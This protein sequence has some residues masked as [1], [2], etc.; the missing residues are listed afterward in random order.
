MTQRREASSTVH[1]PGLLGSLKDALAAAG[2]AEAASAPSSP[3]AGLSAPE[4]L[5]PPIQLPSPAAVAHAADAQRQSQDGQLGGADPAARGRSLSAA[6]AARSARGETLSEPGSSHSGQAAVSA[7]GFGGR[8]AAGD[9]EPPPTTRVVKAPAAPGAAQ[10]QFVRGKQKVERGGLKTDP[11][12]GWLV[13]VGGPGIGNYRP[14]FEGNNTMG[15][16][17]TQRIALDFGDDAI[18]SEEQAYLRYDSSD[19]SFLFVPNLAKTNVVSVNDKRPTGAVELRQMDVIVIGRTQLVF[20]PFCGSEFD[21][22]E[23]VNAKS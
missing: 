17:S 13:I 16:S 21:W 9:V 20:V 2:R 15:R 10:T 4:S 6:D 8:S 18:S 23:L 22:S 7:S 19:R 14:I 1:K 11:V 3:E 5:P 12:V